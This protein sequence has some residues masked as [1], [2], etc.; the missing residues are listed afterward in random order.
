MNLLRQGLQ[1][2]CFSIVIRAT[3]GTSA[4]EV[5]NC[6][7]PWKSRKSRCCSGGAGGYEDPDWSAW[8]TDVKEEEEDGWQEGKG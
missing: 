6:G 4:L 5:W 8:E 7:K 1:E 2:Y 3:F